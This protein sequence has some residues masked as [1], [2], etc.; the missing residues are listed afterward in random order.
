VSF[1]HW[2]ILYY[3]VR[4]LFAVVGALAMF[5]VSASTFNGNIII[6]VISISFGFIIGWWATSRS[7]NNS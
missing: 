6:T 5:F 2:K 4:V 7:P 3:L 1:D